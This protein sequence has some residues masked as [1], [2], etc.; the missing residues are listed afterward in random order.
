[1]SVLRGWL[2]GRVAGVY[3]AARG[4]LDAWERVLR[5]VSGRS[6]SELV[7]APGYVEMLLGGFVSEGSGEPYP[8]GSLSRFYRDLYGVHVLLPRVLA[9][10]LRDGLSLEE[11]GRGVRVVVEEARFVAL[12]RVVAEI[13]SRLLS[14]LGVKAEGAG[15]LESAD[16]QWGVDAAVGLL[17]RLLEASPP[18]SVE[19]IVLFAASAPA[20]PRVVEGLAAR[21]PGADA[22]GLVAELADLGYRVAGTLPGAPAAR[23][24]EGVLRLYRCLVV[25]AARVADLRE[26][27]EYFSVQ[28][29][30]K[31]MVEQASGGL[32]GDVVELLRSN[33]REMKPAMPAPR[34]CS[35]VD[36]APLPATHAYYE[37]FIV[38]RDVEALLESGESLGT[39][40]ELVGALAPL[41]YRGLAGLSVVD[42]WVEGGLRAARLSWWAVLPRSPHAGRGTWRQ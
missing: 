1:L 19:S 9:L 42:E 7:A 40:G 2:A 36:A 31:V 24:G 32:E 4:L 39:Y 27:L 25:A 38:L 37:G 8:R 22:E 16:P 26:V 28:S 12:T 18:Y 41:L 3:L 29:P 5:D 33:A 6:L 30:V 20:P 17:Q 10:R 23:V 13:S 11:A 15:G 34:E 14:M 21:L 35:G